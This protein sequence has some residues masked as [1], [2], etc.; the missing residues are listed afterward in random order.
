MAVYSSEVQNLLDQHLATGL[1]QS[2]DQ[3]LLT[4]LRVLGERNERLE[5]LRREVQIGRDQL[6]R[7]EFTV[8]D[9]ASLRA[10]FD[11]IQA[12]GRR[13]YEAAQTQP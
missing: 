4:A 11:T 9:E 10:L 6:N 1:Y 8:Y 5:M 2:A 7:G 13:R 3:L 12:D